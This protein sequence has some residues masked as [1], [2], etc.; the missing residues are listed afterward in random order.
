[1]QV[2]REAFQNKHYIYPTMKTKPLNEFQYDDYHVQP[3]PQNLYVVTVLSSSSL[4]KRHFNSKF[5]VEN[6]CDS[7]EIERIQ[8]TN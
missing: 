6:R 4:K 5:T 8:N 7:A 1:M 3:W 2:T